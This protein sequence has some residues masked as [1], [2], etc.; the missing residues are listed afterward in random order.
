MKPS[1]QRT[2]IAITTIRVCTQMLSEGI[3]WVIF[4]AALLPQ[5][6]THDIF[7]TS[8]ACT[9]I[10]KSLDVLAYL[11]N[12][13]IAL[14]G[15]PPSGPG[16]PLSIKPQPQDLGIEIQ[17]DNFLGGYQCVDVLP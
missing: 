10:R 1:V 13:L 5:K 15:L 8:I 17:R 7:L 3:M 11:C 6:I 12:N 16:A 4:G 2:G 9:T 14:L